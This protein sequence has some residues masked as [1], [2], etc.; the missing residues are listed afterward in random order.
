MCLRDKGQ[1]NSMERDF[2]GYIERSIRIR[3]LSMPPEYKEKSAALFYE[4]FKNNFIQIKGLLQE[5][6]TMLEHRVYRPLGQMDKMDRDT[7]DMLME[8][9]DH[10][11]N[12][13]TLEMV[14]A[15]LA[16]QIVDK[17]WPY[18][19]QEWERTGSREALA[20]YI[21]S[22]FRSQ[23]LSYH[24]IQTHDRGKL[25]DLL[26]YPYRERILDCAK[27]SRDFLRDL[28]LVGGASQE[29]REELM[30][31]DLFWAT[32]YER[33]YYDEDLIRKQ[34]EAYQRHIERL[35]DPAFRAVA[36]GTDWEFELFSAYSYLAAVQEFLYWNDTPQDILA[37]LNDAVDH[38]LQY[39][40]EHPDN[41]RHDPESLVSAREAIRFYSGETTLEELLQSFERRVALADPNGYDRINMDANLLPVILVLW[42]CRQRPEVLPACHDFLK[43]ELHRTF[44]YISHARDQG[45]YNTMQ[46]Y[47]GYIMGDYMELPDGISF[48]DYYEIILMVTQPTLSVHSC[49]V[50][51]I[52]VCIFDALYEKRPELL[53]DVNGCHTL[54]AL[55]A[56]VN[57]IRSFLRHCCMLHDAGKLYALDT[58]NLF[59]RTLSNDEFELIKLHPKMGWDILNKRESTRP[60]AEAALYHHKWYDEK[61]GYPADIS[62]RGVENAILYQIITCADRFD[63]ATDAVGRAYSRG[64]T[65]EEMVA[66]LRSNAG[67]IFHPDLVALF[68]DPALLEK[69]SKLLTT[70]REQLYT[71]AFDRSIKAELEE[72]KE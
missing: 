5:N 24:M 4:E 21:H 40:M 41:F 36:P 66:D 62:Y 64:K 48:E 13:H 2:E 27:K 51:R 38:A 43:K 7:A 23:V 20:S 30:T 57:E 12:T 15:L 19:R 58:I 49:M 68:D 39:V 17:L 29:T 8:F 28:S 35:T 52:S 31:M 14:D 46:R 32:A 26:V 6:R 60:F 54:E 44:A 10:L 25:T 37:V 56:S 33:F 9:S 63:A 71:K 11:A 3:R 42:M 70:G 65:P 22:L 34:L 50:E 47:T 18:Y 59:N 16:W 55:H 1:G 45:T 53:L 61:G 67:R 69:I 72:Q